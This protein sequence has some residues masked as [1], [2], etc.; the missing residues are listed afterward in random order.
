MATTTLASIY[1][2]PTLASY[3]VRDPVERTALMDSGAFTQTDEAQAIITALANSTGGGLVELPFWEA[4]DAS[5]EPNY[6]NDV[7]Q[8]IA[9]PRAVGTGV[10]R[11]RIA[12]LNEGFQAAR[13]V[14]LATQKDPLAYVASVID[15]FWAR[16]AQRRAIATAIGIYN[17]NVAQDA[18]DMVY[19]AEDASPTQGLV[20]AEGTMG[21]AGGIVAYAMHSS[22]RTRLMIEGLIE[23]WVNPLNGASYETYNG[24]AVV[25]DDGLP[26]VSAGTKRLTILMGAGAFAYAMSSPVKS[27]ALDEE[28]A[29][30]NGGGVDTLWTRRNLIVHPHGY[31]FTSTS[32]TGNGTETTPRSAGWTD[33]LNTA[34][35]ERSADRKAVRMAF[36]LTDV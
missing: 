11:A 18:S 19:D 16:Q 25:V 26:L 10:L 9:V 24:K 27:E 32:I 5:I 6:S 34:N 33:L 20:Y 17:A 36:M 3:F 35:W 7:Y 28:E 29:R 31:D 4:I 12:Y 14:Q 22:V 15:N 2:A 21:D 30:G 13:F 1:H 8:D 23:K